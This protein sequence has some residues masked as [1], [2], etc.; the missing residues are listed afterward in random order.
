MQGAGG[1]AAQGAFGEHAGEVALVVDRPAA[2]GGSGAQSS[3]AISPAWA[4]SSSDGGWPRSS[5]SARVTWIVVGPTALSAMPGVGDRAAVDPHRRRGGRD[6][7]VAG[8]ALDLL[9]GAAGRRAAAAIRTSVSISPS[10]TAV[11]YG[12]MWNSS[13]ADHALA[14]GAADH[15]PAP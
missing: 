7:Q 12:P 2:V 3:A 6:R 11:M 10:P 15:R 1:G 13:I 14:V 8:A 5:S 4:N 9:V